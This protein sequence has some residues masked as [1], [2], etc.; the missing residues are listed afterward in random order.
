MTSITTKILVEVGKSEV[1]MIVEY[2]DATKADMIVMG[3]RGLGALKRLV[4]G[5]IA[6]GVV[7]RV[8]CPVLVVI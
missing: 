2:A 6:N 7:S 3:S 4:L 8:S 5:S 1:Q